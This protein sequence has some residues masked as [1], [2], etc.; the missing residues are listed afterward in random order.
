MGC[1]AEVLPAKIDAL[2]SLD[3]GQ[4]KGIHMSRLYLGALSEVESKV[5]SFDLLETIARGFLASHVGLSSSA[6]ISLR[7]DLP[8]KRLALKSKKPGLRIYPVEMGCELS[9][10]KKQ[11]W[12][13]T[14]V[15]YSSTCPCSAAL[16]RQIVQKNFES[17]FSASTQLR[18]S[19]EDM[20][21][22]I[23]DWL[24]SEEGMGA[25]PHGQRSEGHCL[26][27]SRSPGLFSPKLI[28][29]RAEAAL[30][31]PVQTAVKREDEQEF[32]RLNATNL[33]FAEDAARRLLA[34]FSQESPF[35]I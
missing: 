17:K 29:D 32:A 35:S 31:T 10:G 7:F 33:M 25:T 13:G 21:K 20:L 28:I 16:S 34:A 4:V 12:F 1:E 6:K 2:V 27:S 11:F 8:L 22:K 26:Y 24:G 18:N 19:P 30:A 5:L 3:D 14:K 15:T 9:P 23:S